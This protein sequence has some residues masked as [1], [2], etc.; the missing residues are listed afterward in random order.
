ML[1]KSFELNLAEGKGNGKGNG[2]M[3]NLRKLVEEPLFYFGL[4]TTDD[5]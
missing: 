4:F 3:Q 5:V 1:I 2:K